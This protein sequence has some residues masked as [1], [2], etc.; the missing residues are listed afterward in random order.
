[1]GAT[2]TFATRLANTIPRIS[3]AM[4]TTAAGCS[5]A[6]SSAQMELSVPDSR[7]T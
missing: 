7:S 3:A 1:M 6:N 5:T 2:M 4:T